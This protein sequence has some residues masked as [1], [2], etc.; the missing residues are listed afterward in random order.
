MI[1]GTFTMSAV[2]SA[3]VDVIVAGYQATQ[4]PPTNVT[5]TQNGDGTWTV[6][7]VYPSCTSD[8]THTVVGAV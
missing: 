2:S 5:K 6:T 3:D 8:T 1:C 4:P 7:A